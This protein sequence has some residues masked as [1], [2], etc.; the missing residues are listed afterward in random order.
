MSL[1]DIVWEKITLR[2][3][4]HYREVGVPYRKT[5]PGMKALR[6]VLTVA[7]QL[8]LAVFWLC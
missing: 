5:M 6:L 7:S 8:R 1:G 4:N 3:I 2:D